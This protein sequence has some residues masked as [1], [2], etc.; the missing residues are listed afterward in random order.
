MIQVSP[1][2]DIGTI[3]RVVTHPDLYPLVVYDSN[4][5]SYQWLPTFDEIYLKIYDDDIVYGI[6]ILSKFVD[7]TYFAHIAVLPEYWGTNVSMEAARAGI[8]MVQEKTDITKLVATCP[9]RC[10]YV[11]NFLYRL[12]FKKEGQIKDSITFQDKLMDLML[13]GLDIRGKE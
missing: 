6:F 2:Y 4:V 3:T 10:D 12:G 5:P 7:K 9:E 8:K 11:S 13:Y 1:T